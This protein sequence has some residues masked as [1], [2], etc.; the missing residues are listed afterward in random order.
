MEKV[1]QRCIYK[2]LRCE[3]EEHHFLLTEPPLNTPEN[4]EYTAEVMFETFNVPGLYIAV[5]AI[6]AL[7]ASWTSRKVHERTLTGTVID[8]GDGVT[9]VIPVAEGYVIGSCIKH[10]PSLGAT[11][12]SLCS[13]CS[14]SAKRVSLEDLL[15]VAKSIK[16]RHC[17]TCPDIVK[18]YMKYD[19]D[20]AKYIKIFE[21]AHADQGAVE[22]RSG[23]RAIFGTRDLLQPRDL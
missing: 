9:H 14:E 7:A 23:L 22:V 21:G 12:R 19:R 5:Q 15:L 6:L 3:P 16:E 4:R 8:S 11:S 18:E 2:H 1:W 10:I 17:Y 13:R 20:P